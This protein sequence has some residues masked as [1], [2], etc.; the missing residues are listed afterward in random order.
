M[1]CRTL[2]HI[3][4][5]G[6][7]ADHGPLIWMPILS[8]PIYDTAYE[9]DGKPIRPGEWRVKWSYAWQ[10]AELVGLSGD[11]S[12]CGVDDVSLED[13]F[14]LVYDRI[15]GSILLPHVSMFQPHQLYTGFSRGCVIG[16][17]INAS[18]SHVEGAGK[19]QGFHCL[20]MYR[21]LQVHF[22]LILNILP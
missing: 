17:S 7:V 2:S 15:Y 11:F 10:N 5:H 12:F 18:C 20:L 9:R 16:F 19:N 8:V 1:K 3:W 22:A 13:G 6:T 4:I 14:L 21:R